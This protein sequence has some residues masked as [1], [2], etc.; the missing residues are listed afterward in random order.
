[1]LIEDQPDYGEK[2]SLSDFDDETRRFAVESDRQAKSAQEF[3]GG[4]LLIVVLAIA[5]ITIA[6]GLWS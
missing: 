1:M 5:A 2:P 6:L 4:A 3:I